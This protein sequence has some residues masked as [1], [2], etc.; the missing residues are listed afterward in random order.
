MILCNHIFNRFATQ[1]QRNVEQNNDGAS[2]ETI[3]SNFENFILKLSETILVL[4][5]RQYIVGAT[6]K[7]ANLLT[8]WFNNQ[9][10]HSAPLTVGLLHNAVIKTHLGEDFNVAVTNAPMPFTADT[11]LLMVQLGLNLGF[12]LAINVGF[13]FAFVT[14]F[15]I[16]AYVK[17]R[18]TRSKLLQFVSGARVLTFWLTSLV[19]DYITYLLTVIVLIIVFAAFQEPGWSS[20]MELS[21][22]LLMMAAFGVAVLPMTY[23]A[24]MFFSSPD[25]AFTRITIF[26]VFTGK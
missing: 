14:A 24:S 15:Y 1:Y 16:M 3:H 2:V 5:N 26:N 9:A 8:A 19:W 10:L 23:V 4:I 21:R 13:A 18:E 17:E 11:R 25:G 20:A 12:Q 7:D 22:L 6:I